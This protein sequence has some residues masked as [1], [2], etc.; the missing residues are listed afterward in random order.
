MTNKILGVFCAAALILSSCTNVLDKKLSKDDFDKVQGEINSNEQYSKMKKKY[1]IDNLSMQMGFAEMGKAMNMDES[2]IPTFRE[3]I[4]D[5][6]VDFDSIRAEKL[7]I[8]E[9]NKKLESFLTLKDAKTT[10]INRYKG[11]LEMTLDFN[12][13][14][15][16]DIK[17]I[18]FDYKYE[19]EYDSKFFE[20]KS[21]L[22]DRIAEGFDKEV[23]ISIKAEY[24][25]MATFMYTKVPQGAKAMKD[26]LMAGLKISTLGIVFKDKSEVFLQDGSWEYLED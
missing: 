21:K 11:Y 18:I 19:N 8:K 7:K 3:Q 5:L 23:E 26:Y 4:N 13:Q 14:F 16:K 25:S 6:T 20:D 24:N 12:N 17:Y 9:D 1:V 15:G 2:K 22:T 10:S